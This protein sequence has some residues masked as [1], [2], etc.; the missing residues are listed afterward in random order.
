MFNWKATHVMYGWYVIGSEDNKKSPQQWRIYPQI[1]KT[2]CEFESH[3]VSTMIH[4]FWERRGVC[5]TLNNKNILFC[6]KGK[7]FC[8]RSN[9]P[10]HIS[11]IHKKER[12]TEP[13]KPEFMRITTVWPKLEQQSA[14]AVMW[15]SCC[16]PYNQD[17]PCVHFS[18]AQKSKVQSMPV[19]VKVR[20]QI[21]ALKSH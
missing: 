2:I 9:C 6:Q 12:A 1:P 13:L 4:A 18:T 3:S 19:T 10:Q 20:G 11:T 15:V 7:T 5:A 21:E 16:Q 14:K 8:S 17:Q